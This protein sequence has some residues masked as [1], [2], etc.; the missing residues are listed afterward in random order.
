M[1]LDYN[2]LRKEFNE[3]KKEL[4]KTEKSVDENYQAR[5]DY[6]K[7]KCYSRKYVNQQGY[8]R[9]SIQDLNPLNSL[10]IITGMLWIVSCA[11]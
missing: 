6:L 1:T 3:K 5:Q 8:A 11:F 4:R 7:S 2:Q 10:M 9:F